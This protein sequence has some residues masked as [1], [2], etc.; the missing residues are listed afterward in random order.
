LTRHDPGY[1][2]GGQSDV[3]LVTPYLPD[4]VGSHSAGGV[5]RQRS[6][7]QKG[8]PGT[9]LGLYFCRRIVEE[10]GGTLTLTSEEGKGDESDRAAAVEG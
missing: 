5:P 2:D 3:S 4:G 6:A 10:H 1:E 9:G 8:I 7:Q